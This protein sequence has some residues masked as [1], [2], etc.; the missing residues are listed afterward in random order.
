M[1]PKNPTLTPPS[2]RTTNGWIPSTGPAAFISPDGL[3]PHLR[4]AASQGNRL[5][6][7]RV[8]IIP[9]ETGSSQ[10]GFSSLFPTQSMS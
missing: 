3:P 8:S 4:F 10:I 6:R 2:I 1:S 9:F 7:I 5:R